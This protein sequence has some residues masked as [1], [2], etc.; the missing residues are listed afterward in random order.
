MHSMNNEKSTVDIAKSRSELR[1]YIG[2]KNTRQIT[3][4]ELT[5]LLESK[6][7]IDTISIDYG[8]LYVLL[9]ACKTHKCVESLSKVLFLRSVENFTNWDTNLSLLIMQMKDVK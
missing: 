9:I 2:S 7:L 5:D 8:I 1:Q 6:Y 3:R 4:E